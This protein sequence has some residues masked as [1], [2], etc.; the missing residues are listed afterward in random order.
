MKENLEII[1]IASLQESK[2]NPR[3]H[4]DDTSLKELASSMRV[5]GILEPLIVRP[6]GERK[7]GEKPLGGYEVIIG[8]RRFRVAKLAKLTDIPAIVRELTDTE[9]MELQ[10][11]EN[12]QREDLQPLD[13]ARGYRGLIDQAGYD[14]AKVADR[15]GKS[16]S[17]VYQRLK[18][19]DLTEPAQKALTEGKISAGHAILIARLQPETQTK[20]LQEC[21][22]DDRGF[23]DGKTVHELGTW[24]QTEIHRNLDK[25]AGQ[26]TM[27]PCSPRRA[28]ARSAPRGP[29]PIRRSSAPRSSPRPVLTRPAFKPNARH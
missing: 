27:L 8:A 6:L 28:L 2:I 16:Q 14:V 22:E 3:T 11:I 17:Y 1:S 24:I 19:A 13:E 26:K 4:F 15:I 29:E 20:A 12:L 21:A 18:L 7:D 25:P 5:Q 9:A 23:R 10:I